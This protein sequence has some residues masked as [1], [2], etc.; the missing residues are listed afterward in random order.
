MIDIR[1]DT[2]TVPTPEMRQAIFEAKVGDDVYGE[3][4]AVNELQEYVADLTGK[5]AALFVPSG[6]MSNQICIAIQTRP[7]DEIIVESDAHVFYYET[8]GPGKISGVQIRCIPSQKGMMDIDEIRQAIRP[9]VYY[10]P[11]SSL[12]CLEN[13]HNRHGGTIISLD[14]IKELATVAKD[15]GMALHCDGAR[16]WNA[17]AATGISPKDYLEPFDT[18]SVCLSK[19][20]GAPVGSLIL[21]TK[22]HIK[23]ALK[24]RKILGGGM[25]QAGILA[26]AGL[27]ALKN[28]RRLLAGD[29]E[30]AK[31]FAADLSECEFINVFTENVETNMVVFEHDAGIKTAELE[32]KCRE[33]GVIF[34]ALGNNRIRVV[35]HFQINRDDAVNAAGMIKDAARELMSNKK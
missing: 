22:E 34:G 13:T 1:S 11:R 28:N 27:Y 3:D 5:A 33:K 12:I 10:F 18:A 29:H 16:L 2:V 15:N 6:T 23:A 8:G 14:Y 19:A 32:E 17:C 4:P 21:G 31:A 20:L 9:D 30:N 26:S 24:M 35:F 7:G 25:R